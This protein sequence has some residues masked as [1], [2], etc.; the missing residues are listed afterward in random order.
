MGTK[1]GRQKIQDDLMKQNRLLERRIKVLEL[2]LKAERFVNCLQ[3]S[4]DMQSKEFGKGD[5]P[6]ECRE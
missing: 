2:A 3:A 6:R 1:F 4:V 5:G